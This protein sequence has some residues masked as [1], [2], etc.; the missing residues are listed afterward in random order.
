[1]S[2]AKELGKYALSRLALAPLM[3][4][5]YKGLPLDCLDYEAAMLR[6]FSKRN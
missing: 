1:M 5:I 3:L 4:A 6:E 2:R